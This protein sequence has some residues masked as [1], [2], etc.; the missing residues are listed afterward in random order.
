MYAVFYFRETNT[1]K[2]ELSD[3][4]NRFKTPKQEELNVL[5]NLIMQGDLE[6]VKNLV[7]NNPKY[8]ITSADAPTILKAS[9]RF[10]T[11]DLYRVCNKMLYC[12]RLFLPDTMQSMLQLRRTKQS[13]VVRSCPCWETSNFISS[14]TVKNQIQTLWR[15]A[16]NIW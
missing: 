10:L 12:G 2:S 13:C 4:S 7:W 6:N 1:N 11:T 9:A 3:E 15:I 14:C 5:M 8:L 16:L